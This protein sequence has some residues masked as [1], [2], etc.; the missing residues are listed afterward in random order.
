VQILWTFAQ[1]LYLFSPLLVAVAISALVQRFDVWASLKAPID[2]GRSFRGKRLF[3]KSKTWRGVVVAVLGCIPTVALQ[4][5]VLVEVARP[6]AVVDYAEVSSLVLGTTM[7]VAAMAGELPNSF[8]K[9][10]L[11]IEPGNTARGRVLRAVFW[12]WDQV[13]LLT[14]AWL[15]LLPWVEPTARL[16]LASFVLAL[17]VHP[18]VA[19]IGF[20]VGARKTAR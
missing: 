16:V 10:Q 3:G 17:V 4:K 20:L 14:L 15:L 18:L 6:L 19:E 11:G 13:D 5:Y 12:T 1:A 2:G 7:G 9:R 8:V